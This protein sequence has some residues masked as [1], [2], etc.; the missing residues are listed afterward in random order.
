MTVVNSKKELT[1][2]E[3]IDVLEAIWAAEAAGDTARVKELDM[4]LPVSPQFAIGLVRMFGKEYV[5]A[6][7]N[8]SE[9]DEKLGDG[10]IDGVEHVF[11]FA[12]LVPGSNQTGE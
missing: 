7:Y 8:L 12:N 2:D 11:A 10:W 1:S 9:A 3:I 4:M 6:N 5:K